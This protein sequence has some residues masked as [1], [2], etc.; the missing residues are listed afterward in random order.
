VTG[1]GGGDV[2][3][4]VVGGGLEV[5]GVLVG[6][7]D[8]GG[9]LVGGVVVGGV[10]VG[11]VVAVAVR[12]GVGPGD[13][14]GVVRAPAVPIGTAR[15]PTTTAAST[16]ATTVRRLDTLCSLQENSPEIPVLRTQFRGASPT[17]TSRI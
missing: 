11:G 2:G 9:V 16:A 4:V 15:P 5:G 17:A 6:G 7:V 12:V 1:G 14:G 8:V 10:V 13:V 3:G